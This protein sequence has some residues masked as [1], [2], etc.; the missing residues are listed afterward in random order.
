MYLA[1]GSPQ[2]SGGCRRSTALAGLHRLLGVAC[3]P[4]RHGS[5]FL[6]GW[7]FCSLAHMMLVLR[8]SFSVQL[9]AFGDTVHWQEQGVPIGGPLSDLFASLVLSVR[10]DFAVLPE[11]ETRRQAIAEVRYVDDTVEI[12]PWFCCSCSELLVR[13]A[14]DGIPWV[15]ESSSTDGPLAWL[16][17]RLHTRGPPTHIAMALH[18]REF[19]LDGAPLPLKFR[20]APF[21]GAQHADLQKLRSLARG[22]LARFTQVRRS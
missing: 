19:V 5:A 17:L 9:A 12:S 2:R 3:S 6:D 4:W 18:D 14:H 10:G 21:V 1:G 13:A 22:Q 8:R 11:A 7:E 15:V 20:V 16:D